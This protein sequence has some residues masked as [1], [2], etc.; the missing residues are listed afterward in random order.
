[1]LRWFDKSQVSHEILYL[2]RKKKNKIS[3]TR[4]NNV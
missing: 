4:D 1:M 2:Q 3:K